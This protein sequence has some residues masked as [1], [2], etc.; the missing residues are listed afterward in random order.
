MICKARSGA[1]SRAWAKAARMVP[2]WH[3]Q[4]MS[5]PAWRAAAEAV[6]SETHAKGADYLASLR[7]IHGVQGE[8]CESVAKELQ[9]PARLAC[10]LEVRFSCTD[11]SFVFVTRIHAQPLHF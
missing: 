3:A 6:G 11:N 9:Q 8:L 10:R 1:R 7:E 5:R 2:P 4:T